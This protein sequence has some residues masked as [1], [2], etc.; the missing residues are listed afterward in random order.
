M[1]LPEVLV[2]SRLQP[3]VRG[4]RWRGWGGGGGAA[5]GRLGYRRRRR[6]DG[7]PRGQCPCCL[8]PGWQRTIGWRPRAPRLFCVPAVGVADGQ[9]EPA[10]PENRARA[11]DGQ[12][13]LFAVGRRVQDD[14]A[15][16]L[17]PLDFVAGDPPLRVV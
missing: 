11:A 3:R 1:I 4:P 8:V 13:M 16:D 14:F 9:F 12:R 2:R 7:R 6:R 17:G 10:T 5:R 15:A